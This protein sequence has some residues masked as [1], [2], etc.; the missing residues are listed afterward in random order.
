MIR[1]SHVVAC[2]MIFILLC[3]LSRQGGLLKLN[4]NGRFK[5][6]FAV[7]VLSGEFLS[8]LRRALYKI[9]PIFLILC[10]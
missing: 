2:P 5:L 1:I 8:S 7:L 4:R 9:L 6:L 10:L 3:D